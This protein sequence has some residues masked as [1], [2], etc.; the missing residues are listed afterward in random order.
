M[1]LSEKLAEIGR[2]VS[3]LAYDEKQEEEVLT[4]NIIHKLWMM[5]PAQLR[6]IYGNGKRKVRIDNSE[7]AYHKL[8]LM[9]PEQLEA[10]FG[11]NVPS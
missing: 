8:W 11:N 2:I 7:D 10:I 3:S 4:A 1:A 6:A 9:S 5:S